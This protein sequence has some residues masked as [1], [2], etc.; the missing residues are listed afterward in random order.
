[1]TEK[2]CPFCSQ[3]DFGCAWA[4]VDKFGA[5]ITQAGGSYRF[6]REQ[7]FNFCPVCGKPRDQMSPSVHELEQR[8]KRLVDA[9][10]VWFGAAHLSWANSGGHELNWSSKDLSTVQKAL[11][12]L[13]EENNA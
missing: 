1:M 8:F 11:W 12:K 3:F 5:R 2:G 4:E 10:S 13:K 7:Q 6:P 9:L